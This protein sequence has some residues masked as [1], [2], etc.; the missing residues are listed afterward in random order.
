MNDIEQQIDLEIEHAHLRG[1]LAFAN[2]MLKS[3]KD[4]IDKIIETNNDML[5][6][7]EVK[8]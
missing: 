2:S 6:K 3:I 5:K 8:Q 1:Q 4:N 7:T